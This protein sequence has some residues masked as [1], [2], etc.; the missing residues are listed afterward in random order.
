[1]TVIDETVPTGT[2]ITANLEI[3]KLCGQRDHALDL[4]T[5]AL[6]LMSVATSYVEE[7]WKSKTAAADGKVFHPVDRREDAQYRRIF[8]P[9]D[10][11]K[12]LA[13]FRAE[14]DAAIWM[15]VLEQTGMQ[16]LMDTQAR[17]EFFEQLSTNPP[18]VSEEAIAS[19]IVGLAE[20]AS[21]IF[22]RGIANVFTSLDRRFR[23]HD[24]FQLNARIILTNMFSEYG[25]INYYG[26]KRQQFIDVERVFA[27]LDGAD[28]NGVGLLD[29]IEKSRK[30]YGRSQSVTESRY[31]RV[32]GFMNGNAHLWFMRPDL[33]QKVNEQLAEFYGK[34][35]PDG[36]AKEDPLPKSGLP[37][38]DLSFYATPPAVATKLVDGKLYR[39]DEGPIRI[40]EPSAGTGNIVHAIF[41][42]AS[43]RYFSCGAPLLQIDAVE[44]EPSRA[45][46]LRRIKGISVY[47][48]NFLAMT[49]RPVYD[50]IPMNPPFYGTHWMEHVRHAF[51]FLAPGGVLR[52]VLPSSVEFG[53][54][55]Q[56]V[57]F[58]E[59]A[60]SVAGAK[61]W[62]GDL[63]YEDLPAE[64]FA[65]SG[66]RVQTCILELHAPCAR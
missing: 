49:P 24:A 60:L 27:V 12:S 11:E 37:A 18:E 46:Q 41:E 20:D 47:Q 36:V 9:I 64:S 58:R 23:S 35:L 40:L 8:E 1:M 5:K 32:R 38:K 10:V 13:M 51:A 56:H 4:M 14:M 50:F 31:L 61:R 54:T 16:R 65:S 15:R 30:G 17:K 2:A 43:S 22:Q 26:D 63:W 25:G 59:W 45:A 34:V 62:G 7:A 44:I 48:E 57:A 6:G 52:T 3:T 28:P 53:S 33:V 21:L 39:R 29:L 19:A 55:K 42:R 66:T